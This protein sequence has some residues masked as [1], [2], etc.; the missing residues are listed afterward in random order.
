M[1][2]EGNKRKDEQLGMSHGTA[3]A[4]L[5]KSLMFSLIKETGR[6]I[7]FQCGKPIESEDDLSIEH[8]IPWLDSE[9]PKELFF[10]LNNIA[11]SH[12]SCNSGAARKV[13]QKKQ[14]ASR[15]I[16]RKGL[17]PLCKLKE[18]DVL[19]I[20]QLLKNKKVKDIAS[21]YGIS[22]HT[23][24]RIAQGKTFSYINSGLEE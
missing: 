21:E 4:R 20:R 18:Q 22:T 1:S 9:N 15:E 3:T 17:H 8:K 13:L 12:L 5:K 2:K 10:N 14:A 23:I 11:F 19:K 16:C 24:Y 7:C 6:N